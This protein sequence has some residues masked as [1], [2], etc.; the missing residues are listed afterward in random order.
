M[1][2]ESEAF[3]REAAQIT[4]L[5]ERMTDLIEELRA[6]P[7]ERAEVLKAQILHLTEQIKRF[8]LHYMN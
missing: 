1:K 6:A 4:A 5:L 2:P 8:A 7:I 3:I